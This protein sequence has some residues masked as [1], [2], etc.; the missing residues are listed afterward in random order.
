MIGIDSTNENTTKQDRDTRFKDILRDQLGENGITLTV[1]LTFMFMLSLIV[2]I[3]TMVALNITQ[4]TSPARL[5][6]ARS[7]PVLLQPISE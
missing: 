3:I 4:L 6:T 7:G 2:L 5:K 1:N